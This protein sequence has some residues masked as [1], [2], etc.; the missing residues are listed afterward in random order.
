MYV[1]VISTLSLWLII[2]VPGATTNLTRDD[3]GARPALTSRTTESATAPLTQKTTVTAPELAEIVGSNDSDLNTLYLQGVEAFVNN[4][5]EGAI[6]LWNI[7]AHRSP[8]YPNIERNLERA[9][10]KLALLQSPDVVAR[11]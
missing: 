7:V 8:D 5:L 3:R 11:S 2:G 10:Q 9:R 4:D 6:R 1:K